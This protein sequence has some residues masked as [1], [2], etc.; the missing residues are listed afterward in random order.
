M[1][2]QAPP[3]LPFSPSLPPDDPVHGNGGASIAVTLRYAPI[4][5]LLGMF[6]PVLEIDGHRVPASWGRVVQPVAFGSHRVH[7]HVPYL[8]PSRVGVAEATV[9]VPPGRTVELE[10]RAPLLSFLRGALGPPPQQYPGA[11]GALILL[12]VTMVLGF[13]ACAG[14]ALSA[15]EPAQGGLYV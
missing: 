5:F 10:Y 7:V 14:L 6:P 9:A 4:A 3:F 11:T 2:V 8:V 15:G 13:C 1:A 12:I